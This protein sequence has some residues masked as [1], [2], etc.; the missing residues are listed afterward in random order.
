M[1]NRE[2][3]FVVDGTPK[4]NNVFMGNSGDFNVY[5]REKERW[6]WKLRAAAPARPDTPISKAVVSIRYFFKDRRRRDPDNFSGKML[7]DPI[8]RM[9]FLLDDSFDN[10]TLELAAEVDPQHPRT[11]I[12]VRE[13]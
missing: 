11:E 7:L 12:R 8:V 13:V 1:A 9:K 2:F 10:I 4:S 6:F 5:R 3:L